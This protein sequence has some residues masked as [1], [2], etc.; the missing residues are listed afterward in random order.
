[1]KCISEMFVESAMHY[2]PNENNKKKTTMKL[3][4]HQE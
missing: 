2:T 1:M 4:L 3:W